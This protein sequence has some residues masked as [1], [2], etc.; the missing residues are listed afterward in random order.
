[1]F[2]EHAECLELIK[3]RKRFN[4]APHLRFDKFHHNKQIGSVPFACGKSH[5]ASPRLG[6]I[7]SSKRVN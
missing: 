5:S 4:T 1:M 7:L 2:V 6:A 3:G